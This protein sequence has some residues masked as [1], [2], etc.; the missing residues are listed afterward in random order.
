M[1]Q[2][3]ATAVTPPAGGATGV[4]TN[5][6]T[7]SD[8]ANPIQ[9]GSAS[10]FRRPANRGSLRPSTFQRATPSDFKGANESVAT[11]RA[12]LERKDKDQ[13]LAFQKSL[14]QHVMTEFKNPAE[15]VVAVRD[16]KDP[17]KLLLKDMPTEADLIT[18]MGL[19]D[20]QKKDVSMMASITKL[21]GEDMKV[22]A[23][24][25]LVLK[26]NKTK[27][28][29]VIWGQCTS[30]LQSEM[31][32]DLEYKAKSADFDCVWLLLTLKLLSAGM[33]K[34]SNTYVSTFHALK[35]FYTLRQSREESMEAYHRRFESA[36]ATADMSKGNL[37]T[38]ALSLTHI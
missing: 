4:N 21:F 22:F 5:T 19:T 12:R 14:E 6:D 25:R 16:I 29:G 34:N 20:E 13:F 27:L 32:G 36:V 2:G 35:G 7:S 33:D 31:M 26:Q 1:P 11:L 18:D 38:H 15:I 9:S 3:A 24:Q 17:V 30:A 8:G 37:L 10:R 23:G 28:Y